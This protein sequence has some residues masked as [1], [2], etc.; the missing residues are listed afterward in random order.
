M[1]MQIPKPR[2]EQEFERC[3]LILW[4][5]ILKDEMAQLHGRRGQS[6]HG[7][8]I[9]GCRNDKQ[10][11]LVGIQCKLKTEGQQLREQEVRD[12]VEKAL[13]FEPK[14]SE[15]VIVTTAPDD[16]NIQRLV[17]KLSICVSKGRNLRL[18]ITIL[19]WDSLQLEVQRYPEALRAFYLSYTPQ[20]EQI[21]RAIEDI[22]ENVS[23][24]LSSKL[25]SIPQKVASLVSSEIAIAYSVVQSEHEQNINDYVAL[26]PSK[27]RTALELLEKLEERISSSTSDH[28]RFRIKANI[29]ACQLELGQKNEAANG[30]IAAWNLAP[31]DP[32]AIA[33]KA[34]G[35]LLLENWGHVRDFAEQELKKHPS[36]AR[37]AACYLQSLIHDES[38][39]DPISLI[40]VEARN[41][42]E[43]LG[44]HVQWIM[45]RG[46]LHSWWDTAISAYRQFP[47][48]EALQELGASALLSRSIGGERYFYGQSLNVTNLDDVNE[49]IS[50]Y[51][52]LWE[53]VKDRSVERSK[54]LSSIPANLMTAYCVVGKNEAAI[55]LG[56][57]AHE[58]FPD[59]ENINVY[60][61]S[62]LLEQGDTDRAS[63]LILG[64]KDN[65]QAITARFKIAIV[66]KDWSVVLELVEKYLDQFPEPEQIVVR[67]TGVVAR[68]ELAG[69]A[70]V[71]DILE[72]EYRNFEGDTRALTVLAQSARILGI[73]DASR[74][75]FE[76]A[77]Q[78]FR[79]GDDTYVARL[80]LAEEALSRRQLDVII[81]ALLGHVALDHDNEALRTL[82]QALVFDAPIR[83]R[84][85]KFFSELAP[86]TRSDSFFQ[87]LEGILHYNRGA[88]EAAINPLLIAFEEDRQIYTLLCMVSAYFATNNHSAIKKLINGLEVEK[89]KGSP[90]DHIELSHLL[91]DYYE[92]PACA[93]HTAYEAL[94]ADLANAELGQHFIGLVLRATSTNQEL[95]TSNVVGIGTWIRL[96]S[97]KGEKYEALVGESHDRPW[98]QA[99]PVS[100][101]FI[102]RSLGLKVGDE[103]KSTNALGIEETWTV[104]DLKPWW[105]QALHHLIANFEQMFPEAQ[106]FASLTLADGDIE[107]VLEQVRRLSEIARQQADGY[108]QHN[109]P[110]VTAAG[111]RPGGAVAFAQYLASE[112]EQVKVCTGTQDERDEAL[113]VIQENGRK[114]AVL[115]AFTAWHAAILGVLPVL[116]EVLGPLAIPS[117]ELHRLGEL[118]E[119]HA[120][121]GNGD[122]MSL[123][124]RDGQYIRSVETSEDRAKRLSAA[125][126]LIETIEKHCSVE[127]VQLPDNLSDLGEQ[128]IHI[129]PEGAFSVGIMAGDARILVSEDIAIR[130]YSQEAFRTKGVWIQAV[131]FYAMQAGKM[132]AESYADAV[133]YLAA[134][135][136]GHVFVCVPD[137]LSIFERDESQ[138]LEQSESLYAYVGGENAELQSNTRI[139]A[140]FINIIWANAQPIILAENF[141]IDAKTLKVTNLMFHTLILA[142]RNGEWARWAASLYQMLAPKPRGYLLHW[143]EENFLP[144]RQIFASLKG[145]FG[146]KIRASSIP[147]MS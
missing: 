101:L 144:V 22:P 63:E 1:T 10:D 135:R 100:N 43:V 115:D 45:E 26:I 138:D 64:L 3:N 76:S 38:V 48:T 70:D 89:L 24:K 69:S 40:P 96:A 9:L 46:E 39:D 107:P 119:D 112:G 4:R 99:V 12:E 20:T 53:K 146:A 49:A 32:K 58:R 36:N 27:P 11:H 54:G 51:E 25:D 56:C 132:S 19:G 82:A 110:L 67:A 147:S 98:G 14:L 114:G 37:L 113:R 30:L 104:A 81:E 140:G 94:V 105:L 128:L 75:L 50:I 122:S 42:P 87:R 123:D 71:R 97:S 129:P 5:C 15:Y 6:Q 35:F 34:L 91:F 29:A 125:R 80:S 124:Y 133:V 44:T 143:C 142:K 109:I 117:L 60:L 86:S 77:T 121:V 90:L 83:D 52:S 78:A 47:E 28:V 84:A 102:S 111:V 95:G 120:D 93:L 72:K 85:I 106:G 13:T 103:F 8:D 116:E 130:H 57:Q 108:I 145:G 66:R 73:E 127:P 21:E 92:E 74:S 61:A 137:L 59:E 55:N 17:R 79:N 131:L 41:S 18:K 62:L 33:N 136:H 2:D 141:P 118:T 31:E 7:V 23:V 88:P 65:T 139:A 16:A 68:M 134:H 126:S